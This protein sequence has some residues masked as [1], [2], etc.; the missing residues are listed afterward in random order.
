MNA[1]F[2]VAWQVAAVLWLAVTTA[3]PAGAAT[4]DWQELGGGK[5][6]IAAELD[7][8]TGQISGVV[9]VQLDDGWKTYWREPGDSG[10]PPQFDFSASRNFAADA[11]GYPVPERLELGEAASAGYHGRV[12]FSFTGAARDSNGAI[13]LQLLIGVCEQICIPASAAFL[14]PLSRLRGSDAETHR[15]IAEA[16]THMAGTP[17][18]DMHVEEIAVKGAAALRVRTI[19]AAGGDVALFATGPA[20]WRMSPARLVERDGETAIFEIP[21]WVA[22]NGAPQAGKKLR[23]TLARDGLGVEQEVEVGE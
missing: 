7:P 15:L 4:S 12:L 6:R 2:Y 13:D 11:I 19:V 20:D 3:G 5:A 9:E 18:P 10:I 8:A 1:G 23:L 17:R 14:L 21:L 22:G 16:Q